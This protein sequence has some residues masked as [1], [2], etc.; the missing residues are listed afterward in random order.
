[1]HTVPD[2]RYIHYTVARTAR[3]RMASCTS[4]KLDMPTVCL[5]R[6]RGL[7][8][9]EN[10]DWAYA[11]SSARLRVHNRLHTIKPAHIAQLAAGS[12]VGCL[13]AHDKLSIP[14]QLAWFAHSHKI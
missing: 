1:M 2:L 8:A 6:P 12:Q 9:G 14:L 11:G 5:E 13:E 7:C 3:G 4:S 10:P